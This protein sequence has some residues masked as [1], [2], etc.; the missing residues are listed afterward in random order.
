M[1]TKTILKLCLFVIFTLYYSVA[2]AQLTSSENTAKPYTPSWDTYEFMKYG[3]VGASLYTG[4]INYS[5]PI[6]EYE[7]ED[8]NYGITID[9]ATNGFR[10]N[11]K[12]GFLGHGWSINSPGMITRE[13]K[14]LA[15]DAAKT[16]IAKGGSGC[17]LYGYDKNKTPAG[18][19]SSCVLVHYVG[20]EAFTAM[21]DANNVCYDAQPDIYRFNFCGYSGSF[22]RLPSSDG[23]S[24]LFFDCASK[25]KSLKIDS[26]VNN[27][28]VIVDGLG[29]KYSFIIG[30]YTK[31]TYSEAVGAPLE[32]RIRQWNLQKIIAPNGRTME[33]IYSHISDNEGLDKSERNVT[34]TPSLSYAFSYFAGTNEG[35]GSSDATVY[36]SDNF[37]SKL[38]G[39]KF[40]DGTCVSI[41][42]A[43]G[44]EERRYALPN[45]DIRKAFGEN[46]R[47]GS[48]MICSSDG[49]PFKKATFSYLTV[50]G[51]TSKDNKL[52]FLKSIDI[53]GQ[54]IFSFEYNPMTAYPPLGTIK[55][56]HW[57]Y[58]NGE[59]GGFA[60][61]K[62]LSNLT[63]DSE[64]NEHYTSNFR[65]NPD[66][67]S[68]LSGT[69]SK[70]FY[71]TGGYSTISYEPH[72]CSQKVVRTSSTLFLPML[73]DLPQ[74]DTVGG[75]R[76]KQVI[77]FLPDGTPS[78]T[79]RYEYQ[80][81]RDPSLSSGILI[82]T[83][84]YG[85]KY[86]TSNN[87]AVERFNLCNSIYDFTQTHIEYS[88][89][90]EYRSNAG[91]IDYFYSTYNDYP[92]GEGVE[93]DKE[94]RVHLFGYYSDG[95]NNILVGFDNPDNLVENLLTPIASAQTK[96]GLLTSMKRYS[97]SGDLVSETKYNYQ[98]PLVKID[99]IFTQ[100][101]E[102]AKDVFYPRY[103]I[104]LSSV[105]ESSFFGK[106]S[107][108]NKKSS[109]FNSYGMETETT[110]VT[111][112]G[113][114]IVDTYM[115]SGDIQDADG[116]VK[117]ML[118]FH[119]VNSLLSHERKAVTNGKETLIWKKRYNYYQ[120]DLKNGALFKV[121]N[122]EDWNPSKGWMSKI[123]YAHDENGRI[124]QQTDSNGVH[125]SYLWGYK[126]MFPL[127]TAQNA[128]V[129]QLAKAVTA[130]GLN[131]SELS[132][133]TSYADDTFDRL[134]ASANSL[135][136]S[137]IDI[138]KFK[139]N[140]G[141]TEH[142]MPNSLKTY[143]SYDGY[144]RL[145]SEADYKH[146]VLKQGEYNLVSV[147]PFT[148]SMS[149][150]DTYVDEP[151]SIAV[152][153][154]GGTHSYKFA[155]KIYDRQ[156]NAMHHE[157]ANSCGIIDITPNKNGIPNSHYRVECEVSDTISG[158]KDFLC[159]DFL[160]KPAR[161]QFSNIEKQFTYTSGGNEV[162][163]ANIYTDTPTDVTFGLDLVSTEACSI[164]IADTSF[165][166]K[167]EKDKEFVVRLLPGNNIV[168]MEF[169]SST[170]IFE[171]DLWMK[172]AT[173]GHE[174][175]LSNIISVTY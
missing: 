12:S 111:S 160:V 94:N 132:D 93:V 152:T 18:R 70:I 91:Y 115:Y 165:S 85:I 79:V 153:A 6:Y 87:K 65:R 155:F 119:N 10:V 86:I 76:V 146:R 158:E 8:F 124:I 106:A 129:P 164:A 133:A 162:C 105:E 167:R 49:K 139:P 71:P 53:S 110:F 98:F 43:E 125:T 15:D 82:N 77:T 120:P 33:F 147:F 154:N 89:V 35:Y 92:D 159:Q 1:G 136:S 90:R 44:T 81:E 2:F 20:N 161:L 37:S 134:L 4:T 88:N 45:G 156:N 130:Q 21:T 52:T 173:N 117:N 104:E 116:Q 72:S 148:A 84:R 83:P 24:F 38:T 59:Y 25:S 27:N 40:P 151:L 137:I 175:S 171:A 51:N 7:D 103:N 100:T 26:L 97:G 68:A 99:T 145:V 23:K 63:F 73:T 64:Y 50:G 9:Y 57:G 144:G 150:L 62:L 121:A 109:V 56:D 32:K 123:S 168:K 127:M 13:I 3:A 80:S 22:R 157:T 78:D 163:I 14:G 108:V 19:L 141:L 107:V 101:G 138:Y 30:E 42:Y 174:I 118:H 31:S 47:I 102:V 128:S 29:Y 11:H 96:R 54:G 60:T 61:K 143:Y 69:L 142:T 126:G 58:Y 166:T 41:E 172:E 17:Q 48:I 5:I 34:Y 46:K 74:N 36:E 66:F 16:I 140:F 113:N 39:I 28:I 67:Q 131:I 55:S 149:C 95:F 75:V 170:A 122:I 169:P 135:P 112:E 114:T